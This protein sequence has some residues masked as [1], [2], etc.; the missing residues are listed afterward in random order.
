MPPR[1]LRLDGCHI[2]SVPSPNTLCFFFLSGLYKGLKF[3]TR[4]ED[5]GEDARSNQGLLANEISLFF[6][7]LNSYEFL[8]ILYIFAFLH[9]I[10]F[11]FIRKT[12]QKKS[13]GFSSHLVSVYGSFQILPA[14]QA[15]VAKPTQ[16]QRSFLGWLAGL[17]E[18]DA[19]VLVIATVWLCVLIFSFGVLSWF[20]PFQR[21]R[22]EKPAFQW[23][24]RGSY[25][26]W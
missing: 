23:L 5:S 9:F 26:L 25:G 16:K 10:Y 13:S 18:K 24:W 14:G 8:W 7:R 4:L 11:N 21:K 15:Q 22:D 17:L 6:Q 20:C 3:Q 19:A 12:A 2:F 1:P